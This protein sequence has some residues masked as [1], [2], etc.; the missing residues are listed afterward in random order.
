MMNFKNFQEYVATNISEVFPEQ[1]ETVKIQTV[2][3]NNGQK[4]QG[5]VLIPESQKYQAQVTIPTIYLEPLYSEY[6]EGTM[7]MDDILHHITNLYLSKGS[8]P[9]EQEDFI[10]NF[11]NYDFVKDKIIMVLI[12]EERN[13]DLLSQ[14]PHK[15]WQDLAIIYKVFVGETDDG[16]AFTTIN[17]KHLDLWGVSLE[18]IH[19]KAIFNK[20]KLFPTV[21]IPMEQIIMEMAKKTGCSED[22]EEL[23]ELVE[24]GDIPPMFVLTNSQKHYGANAL[25]NQYLLKKL[26]EKTNSDLFIFPSSIHE[27]IVT[28]STSGMPVWLAKDMV[29]EVNLTAVSPQEYLSDSVYYYD[30]GKKKIEKI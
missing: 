10:S 12:N 26:A 16:F 24:F 28:P 25:L 13:R 29:K 7:D 8:L 19:R 21:V 1:L 30:K 2:E 20:E 27:C 17:D 22:I 18:D 11:A 9:K 14:V 3:K 6:M 23:N 4:L 15:K 5:I